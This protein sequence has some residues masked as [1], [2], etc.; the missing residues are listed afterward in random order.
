MSQ[1]DDHLMEIKP[2][3]YGLWS[4]EWRLDDGRVILGEC[5]M[6]NSRRELHAAQHGRLFQITMIS[7]LS[8]VT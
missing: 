3:D 8:W 4:G 1:H 5:Q 6:T 7:L 2:L